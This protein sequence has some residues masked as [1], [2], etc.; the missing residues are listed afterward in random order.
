MESGASSPTA[1]GTRVVV[2]LTEYTVAPAKRTLAPGT[3]TFVAEEK[4]QVPHALS[5]SGP[6]VDTES[7]TVL[8]P[9]DQ[10][11]ELTATLK[12]GTYTLWCPVGTHRQQGMETTVN[13]S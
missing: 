1:T 8:S 2:T 6:G 3:Y 9:G 12:A 7:T 13:V 5:I 4:G 10:P 11:A